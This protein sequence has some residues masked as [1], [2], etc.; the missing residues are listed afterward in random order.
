MSLFS[1]LCDDQIFCKPAGTDTSPGSPE[2]FPGEREIQKEG[3]PKTMVLPQFT[4]IILTPA[5]LNTGNNG[6]PVAGQRM[7]RAGQP[8]FSARK[9]A[10]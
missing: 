8:S 9:M 5:I 3:C 1:M 2:K 10:I 6:P 4:A 7:Q